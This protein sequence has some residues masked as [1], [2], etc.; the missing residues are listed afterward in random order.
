MSLKFCT[1]HQHSQKK[2]YG[3]LILFPDGTH[4]ISISNDIWD[5]NIIFQVE[6]EEDICNFK[7]SSSESSSSNSYKEYNL[8]DEIQQVEKA[9]EKDDL[10]SIQ[11]D[12][13]EEKKDKSISI[14]IKT[15]INDEDCDD[16]T[17]AEDDSKKLKKAN[18]R[19]LKNRS[20][21]ESFCDNLKVISEKAENP[22]SL[23]DTDIK[24]RSRKFRSISECYNSESENTIDGITKKL[25]SIL[26]RSS[27]TRSISECSS[28]VHDQ[29]SCSMDDGSFSLSLIDHNCLSESCKKSVRFN[30]NI[31]KQIFR[32]D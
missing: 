15:N 8:V 4:V 7:Y 20:L 22:V 30:D 27:F 10:L 31:K 14:E 19:K 32:Y 28:D 29:Y 21:S 24:T 6:L 17:K 18:R 13:N 26:K 5:N 3:L 16:N 2:L 9:N 11:I 25:K 23:E 12:A 1:E